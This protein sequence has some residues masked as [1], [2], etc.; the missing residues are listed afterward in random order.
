MKASTSR[1]TTLR[2]HKG[3]PYI[4]TRIH[5]AYPS[6]V[7]STRAVNLFSCDSFFSFQFR[8]L[9]EVPTVRAPAFPSVAAIAL[10]GAL[11]FSSAVRAGDSAAV[12]EAGSWQSH[13]YTFQSSRRL[14]RA[15]VSP[16]NC[17]SS[18]WPRARAPT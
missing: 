2:R 11:A 4:P 13:E 3:T 12:A 7:T 9:R 15:T 18:C 6:C 5:S 1:G 16:A 17:A 8:I 14:T 10:A